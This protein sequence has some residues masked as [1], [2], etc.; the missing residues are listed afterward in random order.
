MNNRVHEPK[1]RLEMILDCI[2]KL[3]YYLAFLQFANRDDAAISK[4]PVTEKISE[5]KYGSFG[6]SIWDD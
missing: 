6:S 1:S 4:S 5:V 2:R 3:N